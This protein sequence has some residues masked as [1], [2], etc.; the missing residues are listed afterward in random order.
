MLISNSLHTYKLSSH[1]TQHLVK[2]RENKKT[3]NFVSIFS[4][5]QNMQKLKYGKTAT[6]LPHACK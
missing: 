6:F 5:F 3:L 2:L 4:N 1:E